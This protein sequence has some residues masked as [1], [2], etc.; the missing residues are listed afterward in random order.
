MVDSVKITRIANPR[1]EPEA[2]YVVSVPRSLNAPHMVLSRYYHRRGSVSVPM[3]DMDVKT[4]MF[5]SGRNTALRFEISQNL[6]LSVRTLEL[7]EKVY[8]LPP[9][10]RQGIALIPLPIDAWNSV[11]ASGLLSSFPPEVAKQLVEAYRIVHEVNSLIEWLKVGWGEIV[12]SP[13][14]LSSARGGT[15]LPAIIRTQL[16]RLMGLLNQI[17]PQLETTRNEG[18]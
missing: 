9:E 7:I 10:K 1:N 2:V 5:G 8:V 18:T 11:V 4:A 17:A 15:Y 13:A 12:H 3:D 14:D 6:E 16:T